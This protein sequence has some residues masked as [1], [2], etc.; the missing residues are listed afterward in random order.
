MR[1]FL[2]T[3]GAV[4][5]EAQSRSESLGTPNRDPNGSYTYNK[6]V[7]REEEEVCRAAVAYVEHPLIPDRD[8]T[9]TNSRLFTLATG[10]TSLRVCFLYTGGFRSHFVGKN[11]SFLVA[12]PAECL[13]FVPTA[14][15]FPVVCYFGYSTLLFW[16]FC[17]DRS[18]AWPQSRRLKIKSRER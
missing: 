17:P 5:T 4:G 13:R 11:S 3:K 15:F 12:A 1:Y 2:S 6:S 10:S 8:S 14:F 7:E 18:S 9:L 16:R